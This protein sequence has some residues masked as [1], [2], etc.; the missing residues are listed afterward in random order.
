[1]LRKLTLSSLSLIVV[2]LLSSTMMTDNGR[3]GKTG[4]PGET[5]CIDCHGDF[6]ANMAGG[7]IALAGITGGTYTPGTTYNLSVTIARSGLTVFGLGCEALTA[8]N[9]N[10]GTLVI[11]N[12]AQTQLKSATVSGVSRQS[13]VHQLDGGATSNTH[14]FNFNWVAPAAGTGNV[15]LYYAGIAGD[16]DGNESGDYAYNGS[17]ALTEGGG[18]TTPAQP[19]TITGTAAV[20]AGSSNTYSIV[21]VSGATDYIW[22]LP[23]GWTGSSTTTSIT[24]T[25]GAAGGN[26]TVA[27][28]NA[29]GTSMAQTKALTV[30]ASVTPAVSIAANPGNTICTG[31]SVT[32][33]ATPTNGG[34]TPSYQWKLN[35]AN[36]GTNSATYTNAALANGNTVSCVMTSNATCTSAATATSNT[37]TM[38]VTGSVVPAVSIA[39]NPGSTIC[40]GTSV[41]FTATPTNG[42][43]T[44]AY[45]WK[46]NGGNVGTNSATY[47]NAALANADVVS[48]VM[49]SSSG[50]ASP[51]TAT[52]NSITIAIT[53]SVT[54]AV[55]IAA[56]PGS[57]ICSGTSVTFTATPTNGGTTPSYQWKL[58]GGNVGTN[59]ATYT[60]AALANNDAVSVVMTSNAGCLSVATATSNTVT[61]T[62]SSSVAP[63]VAI[64]AN[65]GNTVCTGTS[66]TFTATPTNGGTTP[67]YQ[68]QVNGAPVGTNSDT[69]TSSTLANA[70]V[71]TCVMTSNS[72]CASSSTATS[73]AITMTIS[74]SVA[75]TVTIA[76]APGET[77]CIGTNVTFTATPGNGGTTPAYQWTLNGANVGTNSDTYSNNALATGDQVQ[78][79][80][81]SNSTCAS[82]TTAMSQVITMAVNNSLVPTVS[83]S[84]PTTF[85]QGGNVVLSA[86]TAASYSWSPGGETTQSIT[87]DAAG[88]YSVTVSDGTGCSGSDAGT[89][90]VVNAIPVVTLATIAP[91]CDTLAA[92]ALTG[93]SPAG[94]TYSGTGVSGGNFDPAVSGAGT[95]QIIYS[96][97]NTDGCT[98]EAAT[99]ITVN[100]C[101]SGGC[102]S[103]PNRPNNI[104]GPSRIYCNQSGVVYSITAVATATSY[105]WSVPAGLTITSNTG[106]SITVDEDT[107]FHGGL[108]CV[109]AVNAC[110]T[111]MP[112]CKFVREGRIVISNIHG[113]HEVCH[114]DNAVTYSISPVAGAVSYVWTIGGGASLTSNGTSATVDFTTATMSNMLLRVAV[115]D[116]CGTVR[117]RSMWIHVKQHCHDDDGDDDDDDGDGDD[118][119]NGGDRIAVTEFSYSVYPNPTNGQFQVELDMIQA[120]QAH[121]RMVDIYG[122]QV[123]ERTINLETGTN[124]IA[125]EILGLAPGVYILNIE[126]SGQAMKTQRMIITK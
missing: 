39:A 5:T 97:T 53:T 81:T 23:G 56:A 14:T 67:A 20:C 112:R 95:F 44:P 57:T 10:A 126:V 52:S 48:C 33:T 99:S 103:A 86:S 114:T 43:T 98:G 117:Y 77:V 85:C 123:S 54:P 21:A 51:T 47:T 37:V 113:D 13:V 42:G 3:A 16:H 78:C 28:H 32:F 118:D 7:S 71:V 91:V 120:G 70:D 76:A 109:S 89:T 87:V 31:T 34:A 66:V 104:S 29:C 73:N 108:I 38:V 1:M 124:S 79:T 25:A 105:D 46:L 119:E 4:S 111:S 59:S 8:S 74:G 82:T 49:T 30:S 60:N 11:T 2:V 107:S 58:N 22:T 24:T 92:F 6:S 125:Y 106:T 65:P 96:Y 41:T 27:A 84:G 55:S 75:P 83:A 19:G 88:V 64:A 62:V 12:A 68:W 100:T 93:G 72:S 102:T 63:A 45:Q 116:G 69:Y 121:L 35:G 40:A 101:S 15:T 26:I 61:M 94:G 17:L 90:V 80:M 110:G 18:C 115:T 36:V 50:C 9:T 122:K